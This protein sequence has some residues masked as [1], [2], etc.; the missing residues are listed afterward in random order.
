MV[1]GQHAVIRAAERED[2]AAFCA[3]YRAAEPKCSQLDQ[4]REPLSPVYDELCEVMVQKEMGSPLLYTVEDRVGVIR[5]FCAVR[6]VNVEI[7]HGEIVLMWL[8]DADFSAPIAGEALDYVLG[9]AFRRQRLRKVMAHALD[10]ET[11]LCDFLRRHGFRSEGVQREI[12]FT[13]GRW[14]NIE[15]LTLFRSESAYAPETVAT[16][17]CHG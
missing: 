16:G 2:A 11:A 1:I 3:F 8:D 4:R 13:R 14:H 10:R 15:T 9:L 6:A 17:A 12:V 7:G 5:G